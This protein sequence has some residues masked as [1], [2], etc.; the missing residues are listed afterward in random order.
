MKLLAIFTAAAAEGISESNVLHGGEDYE[1]LIAGDRAAIEGA[2]T[3]A[4]LPAPIVIGETTKELALRDREGE[5][6]RDPPLG[7]DPFRD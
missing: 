3:A 7:W 5:L 4:Q 2:F 1:L 6:F